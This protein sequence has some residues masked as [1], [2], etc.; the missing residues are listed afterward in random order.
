MSF[1]QKQ[2]LFV[3]EYRVDGNATQAA[4]RAGY[5]ART[6]RQIGQQNLSKPEIAAAI[7]KAKQAAIEQAGMNEQTILTQVGH[8]ASVN[9][10]DFFDDEGNH[11]PIKDWTPA[12]GAS[13][14]SVE[15]VTKNAKAGDGHTD[16]VLKLKLWDKPRD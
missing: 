10:R 12:M 16:R 2:E 9:M 14:A 3:A 1:T 6:A 5:S 15:V 11:I 13:V 7:N 4:V 8:L